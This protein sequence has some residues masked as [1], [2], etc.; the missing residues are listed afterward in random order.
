LSRSFSF[1]H[2][3]PV[4]RSLLAKSSNRPC[5][6]Q[7]PWLITVIKLLVQYTS[8][9]FSL[10]NFLRR[11]TSSLVGPDIFFLCA[12]FLNTLRLCFALNVR[13]SVMSIWSKRQDCGS[14][15]LYFNRLWEYTY[16]ICSPVR[17]LFSVGWHDD[18]V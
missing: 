11:L 12:L 8:W 2:Q 10:C 16:P 14:V 6:S 13:S 5:P 17:E 3:T 18:Y 1:I 15:G 9:R 4:C 7:P